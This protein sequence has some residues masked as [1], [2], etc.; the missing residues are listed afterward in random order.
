MVDTLI[1]SVLTFYLFQ[2]RSTTLKR[3][4]SPLWF[5][6]LNMNAIDCCRSTRQIVLKLVYY[7]ITA[8]GLNM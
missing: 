4:V 6:A 8:G 7:A 2:A 3:Y 1:T 5:G